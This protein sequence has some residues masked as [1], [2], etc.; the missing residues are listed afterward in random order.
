[1]NLREARVI[2]WRY[3][4]QL[5]DYIDSHDGYEAALA[6]G[7]D[8]ITAKDPTSDHMKNSLHNIGLA[9]DIDLYRNGVY[10]TLS[11]QHTHFGEYWESLHPYCRWGGRFNDGNH[12]SFA[13]PE[14]VGNRR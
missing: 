14:L 4:R 10:Q 3:L 12:Y 2:F 11:E 1:M 5:G 7:M 8:R 9:Q 13:P 6:E